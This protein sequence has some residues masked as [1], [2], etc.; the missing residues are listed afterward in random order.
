M[1]GQGVNPG[2]F[3]PPGP[4]ELAVDITREVIRARR[5]SCYGALQ[6]T[7]DQIDELARAVIQHLSLAAH[8]AR[9]GE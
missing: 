8:N 3:L 9:K 1:P 5:Q 2:A 7:D 6:I 4:L